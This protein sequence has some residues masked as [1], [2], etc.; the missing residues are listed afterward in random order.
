MPTG[1]KYNS[2]LFLQFLILNLNTEMLAGKIK[3]IF[4]FDKM[5]IHVFL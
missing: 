4:E 3:G 1:F 2:H 5:S